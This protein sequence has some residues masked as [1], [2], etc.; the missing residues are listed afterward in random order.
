MKSEA[1]AYSSKHAAKM[2]KRQ[3]LAT[4]Q[5]KQSSTSNEMKLEEQSTQQRNL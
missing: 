2:K 4:K 5:N 1:R 3:K